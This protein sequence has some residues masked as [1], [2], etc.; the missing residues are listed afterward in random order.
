[1]AFDF[2]GENQI[3]FSNFKVYYLVYE[4]GLGVFNPWIMEQ[5]LTVTVL[6]TFFF[7]RHSLEKCPIWFF[8]AWLLDR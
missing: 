5:E 1:M 3:H 7:V 8:C 2:V 4:R 6:G